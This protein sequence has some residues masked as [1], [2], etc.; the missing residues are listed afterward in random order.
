MTPTM[1]SANE[2]AP[3]NAVGAAPDLARGVAD[4]DGDTA[5]VRVAVADGDASPHVDKRDPE[6]KSSALHVLRFRDCVEFEE[7]PGSANCGGR[8][9]ASTRGNHTTPQ[10][11]STFPHPGSANCAPPPTHRGERV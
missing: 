3:V 1:A 7:H 5:A 8:G 10:G 4:A 6:P 11:A 2:R 9:G